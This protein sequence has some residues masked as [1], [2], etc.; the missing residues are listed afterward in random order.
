MLPH[1]NRPD[2]LYFGGR[3][4]HRP[5]AASDDRHQ[6]GPDG[7]YN[8]YSDDEDDTGMPV[9][10]GTWA[11]TCDDPDYRGTGFADSGDNYHAAPD[12]DHRNPELRDSLKRWMGWLTH[13]VGFGGL[14][15]DFVRGYAPEYTEEYIRAALDEDSFCVGEN[16]VDMQWEGTTLSYNQDGPRG[17]LTV[18]G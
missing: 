8:V 5:D 4:A 17:K 6:Q 9:H 14:R 12:L 2:I 3:V 18:R 13:R 10:W 15:F 11:I 7:V 16:W 1:P